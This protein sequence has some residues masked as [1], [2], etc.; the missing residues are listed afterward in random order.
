MEFTKNK[1]FPA[2]RE[3]PEWVKGKLDVWPLWESFKSGK[4]LVPSALTAGGSRRGNVARKKSKKK[5]IKKG[6]KHKKNVKRD[7]VP[8]ECSGWKN[9]ISTLGSRGPQE[10]K[11]NRIEQN[12]SSFH[13]G[14][15]HPPLIYPVF[16]FVKDAGGWINQAVTCTGKW[17]TM[18][19]STIGVGW[20]IW[21]NWGLWI[22]GEISRWYGKPEVIERFWVL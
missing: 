13:P 5:W 19:I 9:N 6:D 3:N 22:S 2:S 15:I 16:G 11:Q 7:R 12:K 21:R 17:K 18:P 8:S 4:I 14:R 10:Q 1:V 20:W